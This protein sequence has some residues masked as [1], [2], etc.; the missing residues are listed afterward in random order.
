MCGK[1]LSP[2][3]AI[4][5]GPNFN[6]TGRYKKLPVGS[7][8][9]SLFFF[10]HI[11]RSSLSAAKSRRSHHTHL[12]RLPPF[13]ML[14][15]C[16]VSTRH[17]PLLVIR[18]ITHPSRSSFPCALALYLFVMLYRCHVSMRHVQLFPKMARALSK[19]QYAFVTLGVCAIL[20]LLSKW[21]FADLWFGVEVFGAG[22]P[23]V[24]SCACGDFSGGDLLPLE[25]SCFRKLFS[26]LISQ[27]CLISCGVACTYIQHVQ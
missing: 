4:E 12:T 24:V 3:P 14:H 18:H 16:H 19:R 27:H 9:K 23:N 20:V 8:H 10:H 13:I 11:S 26:E 7:F 17:V 6:C 25:E 21:Y 22:D 5:S 15:R 2:R 1:N